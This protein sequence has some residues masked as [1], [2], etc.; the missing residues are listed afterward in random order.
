MAGEM[1]RGE[2]QGTEPRA[3]RGLQS[4]S[5]GGCVQQRALWGKVCMRN[6]PLCCSDSPVPPTEAQEQSWA[7]L[8]TQPHLAPT[9][10]TPE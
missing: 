2:E 5:L 10:P 1:E 6:L 7:L 3:P 8:R 9:P 4:A